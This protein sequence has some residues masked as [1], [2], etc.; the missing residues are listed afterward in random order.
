MQSYKEVHHLWVPQYMLNQVKQ[1]SV[2]N[3]LK[4]V[5]SIVIV[6]T[7]VNEKNSYGL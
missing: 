6:I 2:K 5:N 1:H 3:S 7:C 4:F